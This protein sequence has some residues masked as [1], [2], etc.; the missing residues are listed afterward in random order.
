MSLVTT[1]KDVAL[2]IFE[3]SV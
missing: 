3:S 1:L 2:E